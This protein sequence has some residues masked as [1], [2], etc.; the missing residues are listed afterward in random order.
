M[1]DN[2]LTDGNCENCRRKNYCQKTCTKSKRR[3]Q[4]TIQN[5]AHDILAKHI[6]LDIFYDFMKHN[7]N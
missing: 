7:S 1:A 2:W 5:A 4:L 6:G 3:H